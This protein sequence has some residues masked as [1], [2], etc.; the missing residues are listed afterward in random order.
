M[1]IPILKMW[2]HYFEED[3]NEGLGSSYERIALNLKLDEI[4]QLYGITSA[5]ESPIFGFTGLSGINSIWLAKN[6][7]AVHL[8]D[9][10]RE[11][12]EL[13]KQVWDELDVSA[14]FRYQERFEQLSFED[15]SI[16]FAWNFSAM[17]FLEDMEAFLQELTR[18]ISKAIMICVP[19]RNGF[20]YLSQKYLS[21]AELKRLL[22]EEYII[23]KNIISA[24]R[25]MGWQLRDRDYI[26]CPPWPDIGMAKEDFLKIFK[27]GFLVPQKKSE[28]PFYSIMDFYSGKDPDFD[29][30]MKT[31]MWFE[32][33]APK[34]LKFF[35]AHHKFLIFIPISSN[36]N[37]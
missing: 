27:L 20:G 21:G 7:V 18:V 2:R 10:D 12:L 34:F 28:V 13:V 23:P 37:Q 31:Y 8:L 22:R 17:W 36:P 29:R 9:N 26:D 35:W 15:K 32:K 25:R 30:K 4:R 1:A 5:L 19:N 33:M 16:D 24:M 11:R 3:R 6:H 14:D